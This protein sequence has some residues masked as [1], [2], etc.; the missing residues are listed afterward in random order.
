MSCG[1]GTPCTERTSW[2]HYPCHCRYGRRGRVWTRDSYISARHL[3]S[4]RTTEVYGP[5]SSKSPSGL[6]LVSVT[7]S[8]GLDPRLSLPTPC[9]GENLD[10][11]RKVQELPQISQVMW[12]DYYG[13]RSRMYTI[14]RRLL[15]VADVLLYRNFLETPLRE[16]LRL[17]TPPGRTPRPRPGLTPVIVPV[18]TAKS[19]PTY[20]RRTT[21]SWNSTRAGEGG[22]FESGCL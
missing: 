17:S 15:L 8:S 13:E 12:D 3:Q 5:T 4:P 20:P 16:V 2:W 22:G 18:S 7:W 9:D 19:L 21:V 11:L 1:V 6:L 14:S 10:S